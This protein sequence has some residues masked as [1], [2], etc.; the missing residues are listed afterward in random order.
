NCPPDSLVYT[1][2]V[3]LEF[4]LSNLIENALFFSGYDRKSVRI[5]ELIVRVRN[6]RLELD[7]FDNGMGISRDVR[8][9]V[10]SMFFKGT[11][12][13]KGNG[14]GLYIVYKC[15][16][17][18]DGEIHIESEEGQYTRFLVSI[19]LHKSAETRSTKPVPNNTHA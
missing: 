6:G 17:S 13:S 7:I 5:V 8:T 2:P 3:W 1:N 10:F 16:Q 18:F 12:N 9:R 11:E 19:P 15:V 14:L 4:I